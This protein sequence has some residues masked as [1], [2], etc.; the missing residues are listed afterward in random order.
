MVVIILVFTA[1]LRK[2]QLL[3]SA[4]KTLIWGRLSLLGLFPGEHVG[5]TSLL[6]LR[7]SFFPLFIL[8]EEILLKHTTK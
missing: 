6:L 3:C 1:A 4:S 8:Y 2:L 5:R 7:Q